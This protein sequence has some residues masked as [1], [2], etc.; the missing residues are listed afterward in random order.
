MNA[1]ETRTL[2][3]G[4]TLAEVRDYYLRT[5]ILA[6]IA[7]LTHLRD[8][9]LI[10]R[11]TA[12]EEF[13]IALPP[14]TAEELR[15]VFRRT[16]PPET[17]LTADYYPWLHGWSNRAYETD[18]ATNQRRLIG[19]DSGRELD[20]GWRRS[21]AGLYPGM[22]VLDELGIYYRVKFSGHRSLHL[23]I[24]AEVVPERF[25]CSADGDWSR[26]RSAVNAIGEFVHSRGCGDALWA[27]M[28]GEEPF[29]GV[30][31]VHRYCGLAGVPLLPSECRQFR[32]WMATVHLAAP[33]PGWWDI[34]AEAQENFERPLSRI[35]AGTVVFDMDATRS[36]GARFRTESGYVAPAVARA[37]QT[38]AHAPAPDTADLQS[39]RVDARRRAAWCSM[40]SGRRLADEAL[41]LALQDSDHDVRWFALETR[42]GARKAG[43]S[44]ALLRTVQKLAGERHRYVREAAVDVLLN[45]GEEG[46]ARLLE[47][48][49]GKRQWKKDGRGPARRRREFQE[50]W[51]LQQYVEENGEV[52]A[53]QLAGLAARG[54]VEVCRAA[55]AVLERCGETGLG[56][57]VELLSR[58]GEEARL[59]VLVSLM[60]S[61]ETALPALERAVREKAGE[62]R[63]LIRRVMDASARLRAGKTL[64]WEMR[65]ATL[66]TVVAL[67]AESAMDVLRRNLHSG[68]RRESYHASRG[69]AYLG[70]ASVPVLLEALQSREPL[71]RRRVC[72]ALR[73]LAAPESRRGLKAA[74]ADADVKVRVSAVRALARIGHSDD[75]EAL[76]ALAADPSRAVRRA[77][78]EAGDRCARSR[79]S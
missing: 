49:G 23:C 16:F 65:P 6:E 44:A 20:F 21:F 40:V 31:S 36:A 18:P 29:S 45:S 41:L 53:A 63:D 33:L 14:Q 17:A 9:E 15:S 62:A 7:R 77:V 28:A 13:H 39:A 3:A 71:V 74:L 38:A 78:R 67:G 52:A 22:A 11:T 75:R 8:V 30:Y 61:G 10:Y 12:G 43:V 59:E 70:P 4:P 34:P 79:S 47:L 51:I 73:D 66:A 60:Y 2:G 35:R 54:S 76:A 5:D 48:A 68:N 1:L 50:V 19:F 24:P 26:W 25:R 46:L 32:P 64:C 56:A 37:R 27:R 58:A 42:C 57:L 72:E 69:L 55:C